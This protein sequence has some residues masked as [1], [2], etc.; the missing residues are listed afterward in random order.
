[1]LSEKVINDSRAY[2]RKLIWAAVAAQTI[3]PV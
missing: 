3:F 1:M 2:Y